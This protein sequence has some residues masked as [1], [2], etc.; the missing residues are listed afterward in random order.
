EIIHG[1]DLGELLR[2]TW[3]A[4]SWFRTNAYYASGGWRAT[5]A[6]EGGGVLINQCPHN[7]DQL[8]WLTGMMPARVTAV[9][10]IGKTHP[11][12][13][14]DAELRQRCAPQ[15]AVGRARA[16]GCEKLGNWQ[17]DADGGHDPP[18][19][20]AAVGRRRGRAIDQGTRPEVRRA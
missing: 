11:I 15:R 4:T 5:W 20:G 16:G 3:I 9:A 6:G 2:I 17:R 18:A 14:E 13:V 10:N 12:E 19:G 1:G 7:L 8:Y